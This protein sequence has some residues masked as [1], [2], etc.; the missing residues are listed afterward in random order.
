MDT[1][2]WPACRPHRLADMGGKPRAQGSR[3]RWGWQNNHPGC[4]VN[5]LGDAS[6][7]A[8][9]VARPGVEEGQQVGRKV[10]SRGERA[11]LQDGDF[12]A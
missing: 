12:S 3:G 4:C 7:H 10:G 1:Q 5:R 11:D 8:R 9:T 2:L 6:R